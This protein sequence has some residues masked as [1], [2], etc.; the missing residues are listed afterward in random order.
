MK[1]LA[2]SWVAL[3]GVVSFL[4]G[5]VVAGG[6]PAGVRRGVVTPAALET[7]PLSISMDPERTPAGSAAAV[8][9]AAVAARINGAVVN[10]DAVAR[11]DR[12]RAPRRFQ[13]DMADDN[14][15]PREGSGSGFI[16]DAAGFILT[17]HH[18]IEG[19]DRVT[20]TLGD[21]RVLRATVVG[22]DPAIDVALLQVLAPDPLPVAPLGD[23]DALRVGEWVCAI[24]NPLGYVHSVTVGVV[25]FLGRKLYDQSLDAYIQTDAAIS[26]GNSGGPLINS[27]GQVV[28]M[29]TAV[30]SQASNIGFAVP[31]SQVIG[32][33]PQLRERGRV[34]R[35]YAGVVLTTATPRLQ[36]AL[37]LARNQGALVQDVPADTPAGRAGL[38][39]YDLITAIDGVPI[40]SDEALIRYIAARV[41]GALVRMDVWRDGTK[42]SVSLKL[43][44]RPLPATV[45][46]PSTTGGVRP[47]LSPEQGPLGLTVRDLDAATTKRFTLPDGMT[48]VMI[49]DVDSAGPA[50]QARVRRGQVVLEINRTKIGSVADFQRIV[51]ALPPGA[52]VALF[53][54][55]P[56]TGDRGIYSILIDPA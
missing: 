37:Q 49:I 36:A 50:R 54:F 7:R 4:L 34:A 15:A 28:G 27:R 2:A 43:T 53:V 29:T 42:R 25:S 8:D 45:R 48:G 23:S 11:E 47:V 20:V 16:I 22:I 51:S 31:I 9:F 55:D 30:S 52:A 10:V 19:A 3:A 39:P 56:L 24:G 5:L 13:R 17:N 40:A 6:V 12:S 26:F 14:N 21:G 46:P 18:V 1:A 44:E 32:I 38:R 41:P 33:L 35:G